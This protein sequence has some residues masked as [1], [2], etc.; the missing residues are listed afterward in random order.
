MKLTQNTYKKQLIKPLVD[1]TYLSTETTSRDIIF[2]EIWQF[3]FIPIGTS[4]EIYT[5][6]QYI[7]QNLNNLVII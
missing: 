2:Q 3:M 5:S 1:N 6:I 7:E 4:N